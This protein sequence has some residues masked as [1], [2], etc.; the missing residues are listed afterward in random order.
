MTTA[1][2]T[3]AVRKLLNTSV[4]PPRYYEAVTACEHALAFLMG[5][6]YAAEE[7]LTGTW[8]VIPCGA[9][10]DAE[11]ALLT[12]DRATGALPFELPATGERFGLLGEA[13]DAAVGA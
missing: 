6:R 7:M 2:H 11:P 10:A 1:R 5:G 4:Q 8:F 3:R 12:Y 13:M 9:P